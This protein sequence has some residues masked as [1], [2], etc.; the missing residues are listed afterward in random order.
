MRE[1]I[2]RLQFEQIAGLAKKLASVPEGNGTMLDNTLIFY[3]SDA[4]DNHHTSYQNMPFML[5]GNVN[6]AFKTGRY[7]NYPTY[8]ES[9]HHVL[10]NLYMTFFAA[11]G[12]QRKEFGDPDLQLSKSIDQSSPLSELLV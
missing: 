3:M 4:G 12:D 7:I 10:R 8:N 11:L 9:G 5:L 2:R 1:A 6:G